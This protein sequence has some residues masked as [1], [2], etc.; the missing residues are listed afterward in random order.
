MGTR[1][2]VALFCRGAGLLRIRLLTCCS[3]SRNL[4]SSASFSS[5]FSWPSDSFSRCIATCRSSASSW[6]ALASDA[7][8]S[9][10]QREQGSFQGIFF[11]PQ[12]N[13]QFQGFLVGNI[14]SGPWQ[15]HPL[16]HG[17][18]LSFSASHYPP[19]AI[20]PPFLSGLPASLSSSST[21]PVQPL[22]PHLAVCTHPCLS[23]LPSFS[24]IPFPNLPTTRPSLLP[25]ENL[26][27]NKNRPA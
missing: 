3:S 11:N 7:W 22:R 14:Y 24:S 5:S 18:H 16:L 19:F 13:T 17:N 26:Q 21:S 12:I 6:Y 1:E 4:S 9:F 8:H 23:C 2:P 10:C 15:V 27:R 20:R 25:L